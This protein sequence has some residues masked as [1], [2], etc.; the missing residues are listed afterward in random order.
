MAANRQELIRKIIAEQPIENQSQ[1]LE[2]LAGYGV[3]CTQSTLSRE[4]K[5]MN[6]VK[7]SGPAGQYRYVL[8]SA[9]D[10]SVRR[11]LR[12][13]LRESVVS[14]DCAQNLIVIKTLPEL[15]SAACAVLDG[16][17]SED[18]VGTIAGDNTAFLAMRDSASAERF[19]LAIR[20]LI[21]KG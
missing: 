12:T 16:M 9:P 18:L 11:K 3:Q 21:D 10:E 6:I 8:A 13:I 1:L 17:H 5:R 19:S 14:V 2:A 20:E 7:R 4:I 15:A